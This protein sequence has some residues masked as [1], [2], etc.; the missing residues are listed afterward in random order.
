MGTAAGVMGA[1]SAFYVP[2]GI[3]LRNVTSKHRRN[4]LASPAGDR[5]PPPG[6]ETLRRRLTA[7]ARRERRRATGQKRNPRPATG[8]RVCVRGLVRRP[9]SRW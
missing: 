9:R 5:K 6:T 4:Y 1:N 2:T 7:H 3:R 8:Q